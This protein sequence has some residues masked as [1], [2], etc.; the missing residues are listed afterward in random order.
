ML[1]FEWENLIYTKLLLF[2]FKTYF[3]PLTQNLHILKSSMNMWPN[4]IKDWGFFSF[5]FFLR[6]RDFFLVCLT[7]EILLL[8]I[9]PTWNFKYQK[10]PALNFG[11]RCQFKWRTRW[12][13]GHEVANWN[14]FLVVLYCFSFQFQLLKYKVKFF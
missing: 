7:Y 13:H 6:E 11:V 1:R 9:Y 2:S 8:S 4:L 10:Y 3:S 12:S 5:F 14:F